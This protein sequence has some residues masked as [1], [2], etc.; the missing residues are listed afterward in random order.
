MTRVESYVSYL[1]VRS[2]G[3]AYKLQV[4]TV[5]TWNLFTLH[6]LALVKFTSKLVLLLLLVS[7]LADVTFPQRRLLK[8]NVRSFK[9]YLSIVV[10]SVIATKS[11]VNRFLNEVTRSEVEQFQEH[12]KKFRLC[13]SRL[14]QSN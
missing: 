12:S 9:N 7:H 10:T 11:L 1:L 13:T 4:Q 8:L 6:L 5:T 2:S 14:A 3:S